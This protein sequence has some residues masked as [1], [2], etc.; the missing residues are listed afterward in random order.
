MWPDKC[1]GW[2]GTL[3]CLADSVGATAG[4]FAEGDAD[5][6]SS[7]P[8]YWAAGAGMVGGVRLGQMVASSKATGLMAEVSHAQDVMQVAGTKAAAFGAAPLSIGLSL[9]RCGR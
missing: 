3:A 4:A 8:S 1:G 5:C 7:I 2:R 9:S 6:W